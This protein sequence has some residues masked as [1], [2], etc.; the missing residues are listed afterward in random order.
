MADASTLSPEAA[1]TSLLE[2]HGGRIY[3]LGL[4]LCGDAEDAR[5][6]VQETFLLAY[7]GWARFRGDAEPS[8]WLYRIA[9]RVCGR[10]RRL[11]SGEPSRMESLDDLLPAR[12]RGI[13]DLERV[14]AQ[15]ERW[16]E[17]AETRDAVDEALSRL[18][19]RF[20]MPLVLKELMELSVAD[21][22]AILNLKPATVK[23]RLHRGRLALA[24]ELRRHLP[25]A[26]AP[27]PTH[28]KRICLDLLAAKQEALDRGVAFRVPEGEL[29]SRCKSLFRSLD[30]ARDVCVSMSDG[31]LPPEV[32]QLVL[33][34]LEGG[35]RPASGRH[36]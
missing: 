30:F 26:D 3:G 10:H 4:R 11:R 13:I 7:R 5:D 29:C 17:R 22:A 2:S 19:A 25:R 8:T 9:S 15:P 36:K 28:D 34:D 33:E 24:K 31:G 27:H 6:L 12:E 23:T 20:R 1:V 14:A 32:R 16:L 18:P 21:V 35:A